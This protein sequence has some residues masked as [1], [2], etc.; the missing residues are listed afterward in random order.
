MSQLQVF[1]PPMCCSTGVCGPSVDP[2]LTQFAADLEWTAAQGVSIDRYNLA[3]QPHE[4]VN[5]PVVRALLEDEGDHCLPLVLVGGH[6]V[7][8]GAYPSRDAIAASLGLVAGPPAVSL[9]TDAIAELVALGASI[10][11]NCK[12]CFKAHYDRARKLGVSVDDMA[13]AVAT[14]QA[15]KG[16]PTAAMT[17]LAEKFLRQ[18][19]A[20]TTAPAA[21]RRVLATLTPVGGGR[22]PG[23][24]CC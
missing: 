14:A 19:A 17:A 7:A 13:R 15:V 18:P 11:A 21:P 16:V 23:S 24:G 5:N 3:Q 20:A 4:F 6:V 1:D 10:A 22:A 8:Q 9:Y 2:A 12:P